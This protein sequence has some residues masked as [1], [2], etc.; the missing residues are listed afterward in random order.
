MGL[1]DILYDIGRE[2]YTIQTNIPFVGF[3]MW[4]MD[5]GSIII[6][7]SPQANKA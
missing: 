1:N 3:D 2:D 7:A 6:P 5:V 4:L